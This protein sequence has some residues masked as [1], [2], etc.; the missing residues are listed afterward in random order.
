MIKL[1][2]SKS[3]AIGIRWWWTNYIYWIPTIQTELH[4]LQDS[5]L[6]NISIGN[7]YNG[8]GNNFGLNILIL[9]LIINIDYWWKLKEIKK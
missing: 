2:K 9:G 6:T 1:N 7:R 4:L 5:C 8:E 3:K